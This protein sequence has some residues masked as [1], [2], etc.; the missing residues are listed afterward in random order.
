LKGSSQPHL[1]IVAYHGTTTDGADGIQQ[2]GIRPSQNHDD[3]LGNGTYFFTKDIGNPKENAKKWAICQS[4]DS[5]TLHFRAR[6]LAVIEMSIRLPVNLLLDL[7]KEREMIA[8]HHYREGWLIRNCMNTS[9]L[10]RPSRKTYDTGLM[11]EIGANLGKVAVIAN[12][13]VN[14]SI[15]ARHFRIDSRIPNTTMICLFSN[16]PTIETVVTNVEHFQIDAQMEVL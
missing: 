1:E 9:P 12:F 6:E 5:D 16:A 2:T 11:N 14:L 15:R 8:F 7:R 3:W 10:P 13:H 4:W